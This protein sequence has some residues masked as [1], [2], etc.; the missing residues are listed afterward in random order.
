MKSFARWVPC[1][2]TWMVV[3]VVTNSAF[4]TGGW[5]PDRW[6]DE[7]GKRLRGSPEFYWDL[8]LTRLAQEYAAKDLPFHLKTSRPDAEGEVDRKAATAKTDID[9]FEDALK[10]QRLQTADNASALTAHKLARTWLDAGA[11]DP[12][13]SE[14]EVD[15]EFA[16]YHRAAALFARKEFAGAKAGWQKLLQRPAEQRH[17]RTVWAAYMLGKCCLLEEKTWEE[18]STWFEKCREFARAGFADSEGLAA[19]S[20]GWQARAEY[21]SGNSPA[22]ARH[23]LQQLA[24]GDR[25]AI[26]SLKLLVPGRNLEDFPALGAGDPAS[27]AGS[28]FLTPDDN[29][30]IEAKLQAARDRTPKEL[31]AAAKDPVVRQIVTAHIL[32][33]SSSEMLEAEQPRLV[34]WL[35][36]VEQA[37]LAHVEGAAS[38]GWIAYM[39]GR[40][41]DAQKWVNL[42]QPVTPLGQW[43]QAKLALRKGEFA[44]ASA[45]MQQAVAGFPDDGGVRYECDY[46][47][48]ASASADLGSALLAQGRFAESLAAFWKGGCWEDAAYLADRVLT[49]AELIQF[50]ETNASLPDA[51]R[52]QKP[53]QDEVVA[54]RWEMKD[55]LLNLAGRRLIREGNA[56]AGGRLLNPSI[57]RSFDLFQRLV[58]EGNDEAKPKP[59]RAKAYF[60][61]A[62]LLRAEGCRWRGTEDEVLRAAWG[63]YAPENPGELINSRL[64]GRTKVTDSMEEANPTGDPSAEKQ[65]PLF[66]PSAPTERKRLAQDTM[67][68]PVAQHVRLAAAFAKKAAALLPDNTEETADVLNQAGR[69]L[70]DFDNAAADQIYYQLEKRCPKTQIGAAVLQK[71]WFIVPNGP[72]TLDSESQPDG[73]NRPD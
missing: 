55:N 57:R 32:A 67:R 41:A 42:E 16:D 8:E 7:G 54:L 59:D 44:E 13:P 47:P 51:E 70:Q 69:W 34:S 49:T 43:L 1:L 11:P 20:F 19:D 66:I 29:A 56:E 61:T 62:R 58:A 35:T 33:T 12:E 40:F 72:W 53:E 46:L 18:A 14:R 5:V 27:A 21:D 68:P 38:L 26:V 17:Y 23:Y 71:R 63:A 28:D 50:I 25:S 39:A 10:T 9:D 4:A 30:R 3:G 15:S 48:K 2:V 73:G 52:E 6:L 31:S 64:R 65:V 24:L 45:L 22:A 37:K 60:Q 36:A